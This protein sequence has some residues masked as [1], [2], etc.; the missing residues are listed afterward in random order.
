MSSDHTYRVAAVDA[1]DKMRFPLTNWAGQ[2]FGVATALVNAGLCPE[3]AIAVYGHWTGPIGADS[4]FADRQHVG[5][6]Q[7]G[8]VN[9]PDGTI[10]DP[11]RWAFDHSDH[12]NAYIY[13]GPNDH[14]DEGGNALRHA[15]MRPCSELNKPP[16]EIMWTSD[17]EAAHVTNLV[18]DDNGLDFGR[19]MWLGSLPWDVL[20][21]YA[22]SILCA[23]DA[24]GHSAAVPFDNMQRA[25]RE[26][27][28]S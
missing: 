21:P 25:R 10:I 23:I 16:V 8:W 27:N 12:T 13:S 18:G 6:V 26:S 7:H 19:L 11:T 22:V 14:Y 15:M 20:E 3:G 2:C 17:A 1:A 5:F 4:M 9:C 28:H 24:A